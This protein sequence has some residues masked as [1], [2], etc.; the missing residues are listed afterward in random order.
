MLIRVKV[1]VKA[2][3]DRL[4]IQLASLVVVAF[5][6]NTL[7]EMG[8]R[9]MLLILLYKLQDSFHSISIRLAI[10]HLLSIVR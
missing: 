6:F 3:A 1:K 7:R 10:T 2:K 5:I 9:E 8:K 4:P